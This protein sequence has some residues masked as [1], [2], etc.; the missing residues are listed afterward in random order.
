MREKK[1]SVEITELRDEN[2]RIESDPI[3]VVN[4]ARKFYKKL[5]EAPRPAT[6]ENFLKNKVL[7]CLPKLTHDDMVRRDLMKLVTVDELRD[8]IFSFKNG[9]APGCDGLSFEF[10]KSTFEIIKHQLVDVINDIIFG[11]HIPR[12]MNTGIIKLK[13]KRG[14][15]RDGDNYRPLTLLNVDL[16]IITKIFAWRLKPILAKVLHQ[17]QYAQPGKQI[18]ELNCLIRDLF[19][20]MEEGNQDCFFIQCDFYKAFDS[21]DQNFLFECLEKM[22]FPESFIDFL[23]CLYKNA[24]SKIMINGHLSKVIKVDRGSRQ[25]DP[26]SLYIFI[27]V[28]NPLLWFLNNQAQQGI[29]ALIPYKTRST[30]SYFAQAYADD[31]NFVTTSFTTVLRTFRII[32]Q[33]KKVSGLTINLGKT[34]GRFYDKNSVIDIEHLPLRYNNWNR[35]MIIL[36][37]P[38]GDKDFIEQV[39]KNVMGDVTKSLSSYSEISHTFDAKAIITKTLVLPKI[40][41]IATTLDIP[42]KIQTQVDNLVLNFVTK[43]VN[44]FI[45]LS[46]LAQKRHY[47][48]YNI[49]YTSIHAT[50][51]SLLPIFN[52]V[53]ALS[54][55]EPFSKEAHFIDL[56]IGRQISRLIGIPVNNRRPH[57]LTPTAHY[58][59][60]LKFIT[61]MNISPENLKKGRIKIIYENIIA[62]KTNT[63][64]IVPKWRRVHASILPNYLKTFNFKVCYDMLPFKTK[65]VNFQLDTDSRCNFCNFHP[66]TH[67][68]VFCKCSVLVDVWK[69]LDKIMELMNFNY[70]FEV[71]RAMY[72]YVL[73]GKI[74]KVEE[75]P[76]VYLNSIVNQK[77]W[78]VSRKIQ[79]ENCKFDLEVFKSSIVKSLCARKAVE[80]SDRMRHCQKIACIGRLC[81]AAKTAVSLTILDAV[82]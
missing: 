66:D 59:R 20:E 23:K 34:Y 46:D 65:F 56:N 4:I 78:H 11:M 45:K 28:L 38:Y 80:N 18:F 41:Y 71:R 7:D 32:E 1:T 42:K 12:K 29:H 54:S 55:K 76:I 79:N 69:F 51:F 36:G 50:V 52:Y 35:N 14:D 82:T 22:N 24:V 31:M 53:K 27:I 81:E 47:G 44:T 40:S 5:Y 19:D 8:V 58:E 61:E 43:G 13:H 3:E 9:K 16:K 64:Y 57:R 74:A 60:I 62:S 15:R 67:P 72:D 75:M 10:Y 26:I 70:R 2:G 21:V 39:W 25:G 30:K 6:G 63:N 68:H 49:D 48:G 37:V 77:I 73:M 17:T 33:Y